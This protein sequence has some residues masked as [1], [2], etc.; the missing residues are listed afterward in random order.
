MRSFIQHFQYLFQDKESPIIIS[1]IG[2]TNDTNVVKG[3]VEFIINQYK[4]GV[5]RIEIHEYVT[6]LMDET[7]F[8]KL[9]RL[10]SVDAIAR[11]LQSLSTGYYTPTVYTG[12][13]L[14]A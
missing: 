2:I 1:V 13:I 14:Q 12:C 4:D 3:I 7:Y 9:N 6:N 5:Q 10:D 11:E 8:E